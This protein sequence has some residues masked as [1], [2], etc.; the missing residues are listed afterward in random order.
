MKINEFVDKLSFF[1][2]MQYGLL[3]K[4]FGMRDFMGPSCFIA[5]RSIMEKLSVVTEFDKFFL[6]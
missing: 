4:H 2:P 1:S 3:R 6:K 5:S